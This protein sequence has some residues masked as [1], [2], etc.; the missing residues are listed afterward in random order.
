MGSAIC[1]FN[2]ACV[3]SL[4][5]DVLSLLQVCGFHADKGTSLCHINQHGAPGRHLIGRKDEKRAAVD[6]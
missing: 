1:I 4:T 5:A 3:C 2:F 6:R